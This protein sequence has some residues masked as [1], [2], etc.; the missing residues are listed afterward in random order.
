MNRRLMRNKHK[1]N[2]S[3]HAKEE[4]PGSI[5]GIQAKDGRFVR[6]GDMIRFSGKRRS[7]SGILLYHKEYKCYGIF[8]Y[9]ESSTHDKYDADSYMCFIEIPTDNGA[10]MNI[11]VLEEYVSL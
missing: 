11:E 7:Y 8:F 4:R 5:T 6:V 2:K 10:K 3:Y 9:M 1:E